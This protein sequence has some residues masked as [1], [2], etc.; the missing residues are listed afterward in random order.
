MKVIYCMDMLI[1][2]VHNFDDL[3]L[4]LYLLLQLHLVINNQ[5]IEIYDYKSI[6]NILLLHFPQCCKVECFANYI[7]RWL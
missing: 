2:H 4:I 1:H 5:I 3:L 6:S 7:V